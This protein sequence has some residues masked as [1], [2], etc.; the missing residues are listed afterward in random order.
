VFLIQSSTS[1]PIVDMQPVVTNEDNKDG[2]PTQL[3][4]EDGDKIIARVNPS[5]IEEYQ[6]LAK[7]ATKRTLEKIRR[8]SSVGSTV[9]D[10]DDGVFDLG[11]FGH[12]ESSIDPHPQG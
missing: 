5:D 9:V 6:S 3:T 4:V 12:C 1:E 7:A 8:P 11:H 2:C 10:K